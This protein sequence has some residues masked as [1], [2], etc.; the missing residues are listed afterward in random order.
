[1]GVPSSTHDNHD[2]LHIIMIGMPE[3]N[4]VAMEWDILLP[5]LVAA[6]RRLRILFVLECKINPLTPELNPSAST[7]PDEIFY[8]GFCFLNR[9]L[10]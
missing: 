2:M 9:A 7:L 6:S 1:M 3:S 4:G 5:K 10:R 8:C